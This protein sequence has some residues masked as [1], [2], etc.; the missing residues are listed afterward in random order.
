MQKF[1]LDYRNEEEYKKLEHGLKKYINLAYKK[2]NY[3]Y[4]PALKNGKFK[5][6]L[7]SYDKINDSQTYEIKL[8]CE[9]LFSQVY[10]DLIFKYTVY[11]SKNVVMLENIFPTDILMEA[12]L[13]ELTT[14]KGVIISR[15][16]AEVDKCKVSLLSSLNDD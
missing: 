7:V 2:L 13:F 11:K 5:G 10:C 14:Y 12:H 4:Y 3:E 9:H 16:N 1:T 6:E 15:T 8:P